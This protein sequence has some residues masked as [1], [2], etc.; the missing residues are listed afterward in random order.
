MTLSVLFQIL[1]SLCVLVGYWLNAKN[2]ARQHMAFIGG[3]IFLLSFTALESKWV[4]FALS[5]FIIG[6]QYR[7]SQKKWKFKKDMVRIKKRLPMGS[8]RVHNFQ[9]TK[10]QGNGAVAK[11]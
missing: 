1:G 4:L 5:V 2:H 11:M 9:F 10:R 7:I 8:G 3:H 6:I